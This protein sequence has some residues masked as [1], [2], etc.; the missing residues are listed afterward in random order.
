MIVGR[1]V[2]GLVFATLAA[3]CGQAPTVGPNG[4]AVA[5][6]SGD[7]V[8]AEL[9]ADSSTGALLVQTFDRDL[10]TRRPIGST[11]LTVG[12]G[13]HRIALRARP[14]DQDPAG[15]SSRFYG[16]ADWVRGGDGSRG[17]IQGLGPGGRHE[18]DWQPG[19]EAGGRYGHMWEELE[20]HGRMGREHGPGRE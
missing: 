2:G 16:E 8:Y 13:E 7:T 9:L 12:T 14:T 3:A 1:T 6:I 18:F 20:G 17:W 11:S 4:G 10:Q 19:W 15:T 5:A